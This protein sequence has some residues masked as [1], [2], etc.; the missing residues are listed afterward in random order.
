MV[1]TAQLENLKSNPE[2]KKATERQTTSTR[3]VRTRLELARKILANKE[4]ARR[5]GRTVETD[6]TPHAI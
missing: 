3:N 6:S 1:D 5:T 4:Q 2:F